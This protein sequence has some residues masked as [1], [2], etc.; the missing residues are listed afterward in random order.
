MGPIMRLPTWSEFMEELLSLIFKTLGWLLE[1]W[2]GPTIL[3]T[4]LVI[5]VATIASQ[6]GG[7]DPFKKER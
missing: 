7:E 6:F 3:T 2:F 4:I 5:F 1:S